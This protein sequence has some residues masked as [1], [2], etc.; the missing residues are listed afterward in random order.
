MS[1]FIYPVQV[2]VILSGEK[3]RKGNTVK[4]ISVNDKNFNRVYTKILNRLPVLGGAVDVAVKT[5]LEAVRKEG[6]RAVL[7]YAKKFDRG[8][9]SAQTMRV[10]LGTPFIL[11]T[12]YLI[13][14]FLF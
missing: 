3:G 1:Y 5:I 2:F 6:D 14:A 4:Q 9:I 13:I 10:I 8:S 7:R 11:G 12:P